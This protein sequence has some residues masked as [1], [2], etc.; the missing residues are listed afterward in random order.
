MLAGG[1]DR[2]PEKKKPRSYMHEHLARSIATD[3]YQRGG[4]DSLICSHARLRCF[5]ARVFRYKCQG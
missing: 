3:Y 4:G 2:G 5:P 1:A